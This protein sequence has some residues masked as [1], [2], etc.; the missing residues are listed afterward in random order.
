LSQPYPLDSQ[1]R[2][3]RARLRAAGDR[4]LRGAILSRGAGLLGAGLG[5]ANTAYH[6]WNLPHGPGR[7]VADDTL[8]IP[9]ARDAWG[10]LLGNGAAA[11][12]AARTGNTIYRYLVE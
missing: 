12:E 10:T 7:G 9:A 3:G 6:R 2:R 11:L 4:L 1:C 8:R 5:P